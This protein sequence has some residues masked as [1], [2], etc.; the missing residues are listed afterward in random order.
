MT[1]ILPPTSLMAAFLAG[2]LSFVSPC[3][4]PL[5]PSY[6]MYLTGLSFGQLTGH[7]ER[8][9]LRSVIL[10]NALLFVAGFSLV[11]IA[12]GASATLLGRLLTDHQ[13]RVRQVGG[14][15]VAIFGLSLLGLVRPAF[16]T[17]EKRVH[18]GTRPAGLAG[19][20]MVGA[21]FAAGWTPCVGPVLGTILVYAGS[22]DTLI[23]GVTLLTFY[24]LGLGFPFV[25]VSLGLDRFLVVARRWLPYLGVVSRVSGAVLVLLGLVLYADGL[26]ALTA[27][28]SRYGIGSDLGFAGD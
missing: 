4:L 6:V 25:L 12:L 19:S 1:E 13:D 17:R 11:F 8:G 2:V 20:M 22:A 21:A 23:D 14:V 26:A 15:V 28:F 5:V 18:F 9:E 27:L 7:G 10:I 16:L 24:S 3:V